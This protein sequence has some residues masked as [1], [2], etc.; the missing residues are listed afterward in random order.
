M[1]EIISYTTLVERERELEKKRS[2]AL[3]RQQWATAIELEA[4]IDECK[5]W[6]KRMATSAAPAESRITVDTNERPLV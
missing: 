2:V 3:A 4:R 6:R 5:L 1:N